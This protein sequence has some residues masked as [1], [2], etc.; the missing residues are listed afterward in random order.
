[1]I[2]EVDVNRARWDELARVHGQD[3]YYDVDGFLAGGCALTARER[4]EVSAAVGGVAG[5]DLL[6]LQ[7][8]FG[9]G[10]LSWAR[11]GAR[12]TGLDFS[13]VAVERARRL[14]D[15]AGLTATFVRAD[16]QHLPDQLAAAFDLVFASYGVLCWIADVSAWM[17][18]AATA[19]RPGGKLV[20]VDVHPLAQMIDT[21]DPITCGFPYQGGAPRRFRA[22]GSYASSATDLRNQET[23]QYPHGL[24][25][26]VTAAVGAG[27]RVDAL[28]EYLD[29]D[30]PEGRRDHMVHSDDGRWLLMVGGQPVPV[31][32]ALRATRT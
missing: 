32:Y 26:I 9:L 29:A 23:V 30:G 20:L 1:M 16:A 13:A 14:A 31:Q 22:A 5:V 17:R 28:T 12:A 7:C 27:L 8:H 21:A 4:A 3:D 18:T 15:A 10:T 25:E 2:G 19:M 24:G 6:H 11:L